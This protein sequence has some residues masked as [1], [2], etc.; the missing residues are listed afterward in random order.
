MNITY[1]FGAGASYN[2]IPIVGELEK[3]FTK[4][5]ALSKE[6]LEV[7]LRDQN[8]LNHFELFS[9]LLNSCSYNAKLFG[10]ID[11]YAKKLFISNS[12]SDLHMVKTTLSL[13][14]TIWQEFQWKN[15]H[16]TDIRTPNKYTINPLGFQDID[17]RYLGL[18]TNYLEY[19]N[20]KIDFKTNVRFLTWN[21]DTQFERALA[22]ITDRHLHQVLN[23]YQIYPANK[24]ISRLPHLV[25]LNGIG[26]FY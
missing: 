13:F 21:Y 7:E 18:L 16:L 6:K 15:T 1:L 17:S 12:L 11:T 23:E 19:I 4:L 3:A 8:T 5:Q 26:G 9:T 24:A 10:T 14:F 20:G 25:H 22:I 2:A